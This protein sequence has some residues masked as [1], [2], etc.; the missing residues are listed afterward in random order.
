MTGTKPVVAF[1]VNKVY[2]VN[3]AGYLQVLSPALSEEKR[4]LGSNTF[5]ATQP[6][7]IATIYLSPIALLKK[8]K[9]PIKFFLACG[10]WIVFFKIFS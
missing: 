7:I 8:I 4:K 5:I 3:V 1:W 6:G 2:G 9:H 10:H